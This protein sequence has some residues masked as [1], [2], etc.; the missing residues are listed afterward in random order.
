[1][2]H[3]IKLFLCFVLLIVLAQS[4]FAQATPEPR[5]TAVGV[6]CVPKRISVAAVV[7]VVYFD[8]ILVY[9]RPMPEYVVTNGM[10]KGWQVRGYRYADSLIDVVYNSHGLPTEATIASLGED[11][12]TVQ[13]WI[14][15]LESLDVDVR[16]LNQPKGITTTNEE[17]FSI[18][19]PKLDFVTAENKRVE[20]LTIYFFKPV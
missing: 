18:E 13:D 2:E 12:C 5:M 6:S 17:G 15:L 9:F 19:G 8:S 4:A 1:M 10:E 16:V 3:F 11:Q 14:T 7:A 20:A